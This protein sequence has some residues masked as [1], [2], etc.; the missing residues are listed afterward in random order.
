MANKIDSI[1]EQLVTLM[2][3]DA[4]R[5]SEA[6]AKKLGLSAA[7]VRRRLRKLIGSGLLRIIGVVEPAK[8][9]FSLSV[10]IALDVDHDKLDSALDVLINRPEI[11]WASTTTG[12]FDIVALG[13]FR[14]ADSLSDFLKKELGQISGVRDSETLVCLDVKKGRYVALVPSD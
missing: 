7:T 14:S 6:I 12:R 2:G 11:R 8:F 1:D 4:R 3:Q 10:M 9:G 13:R 5:S